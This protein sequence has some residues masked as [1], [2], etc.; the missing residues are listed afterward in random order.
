MRLKTT[1]FI[2]FGVI[3]MNAQTREQVANELKRQGVPHAEIVLAQARHETGN[4]TSRLCRENHNLF[5]IKHGRRYARYRNW[6][7]SIR[8]YKESISSR[9]T[10][11]D[12]YRFLER[13][14]YAEEKEYIQKIKDIVNGMARH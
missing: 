9:Y 10:G 3:S 4:F 8:D 5:G 7:D 6:K 11:G 12:Y 2:V 13:I 14:H 1:I